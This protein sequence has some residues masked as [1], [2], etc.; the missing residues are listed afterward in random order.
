MNHKATEIV[1]GLFVVAGILCA[2]YLAIR[3]GKL[4]AFGN[5]GYVVYADFANVAGLRRGDSVEIAGVGIGR[6]DSL[7]LVEDRARLA[8]RIDP[9]VAIQE[10]AIASVRARGLIGDKFI[11]ISPG[12]SDRNVPDG[13]RIR[14]TESPPDITD[15]I[16]RMIGGNVTGDTP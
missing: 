10:D 12:A 8:L 5:S 2:G 6:V 14:D 1:V 15:L 9:G 3:L 16:G 4:E 7:T 11:A 13:G